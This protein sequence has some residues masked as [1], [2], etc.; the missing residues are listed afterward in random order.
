MGN[1]DNMANEKAVK[2]TAPSKNRIGLMDDLRGFCVFCMIFYHGFLLAFESFGVEAGGLAY[3][4]FR[5]VQP[6]FAGVFILL[7]G[8]S[9]RLS[10]SNWK[11]G[12]ELFGIALAINVATIV[13]LPLLEAPLRVDFSGTEIWF[14]I[15][16]LLSVS[17]L[18]FALAHK[19]LDWLP[20]AAGAY[21]MLLLWYMTRF[22]ESGRI[23]FGSWSVNVPADWQNHAWTFPFGLHDSTFFSADYFPLIPWMFL[24]LAGAYFGIYIAEGH[25]PQFAY[26]ARLGPINWLGR[27]ALLVYVV[28]VPAWFLLLELVHLTGLI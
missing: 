15:L 22:F 4:F 9:C 20:P 17:I 24:F 19:V 6:F 7:C 18:F 11:R 21:L 3:E 16:N 27:H 8:V 23:S 1:G 14:G 12:A 2:R 26:K 10:H 5:P 25:V 28:H 13:L